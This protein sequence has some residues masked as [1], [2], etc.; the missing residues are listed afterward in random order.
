MKEHE[1]TITANKGK[2]EE[3]SITLTYREPE[4]FEEAIETD[5]EEIALEMYHRGR[6]LRFEQGVREDLAKGTPDGEILEKYEKW[7][8]T[9]R[10]T[11]TKEE[12]IL[13]F[14][15]ERGMTPDDFKK[16]LGL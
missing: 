7:V 8:P 3:R 2:K 1:N 13:K 10:R 9:V 15:E 11:L 16:A 6:R 12:R 5:T 14:A 4:T